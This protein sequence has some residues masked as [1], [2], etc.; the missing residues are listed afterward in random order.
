M[1]KR[2]LLIG[3]NFSPELTGIGKYSGEMMTWLAKRGYDCTVITG[4]PYYPYWKVQEPYFKN[5]FW[6]KTENQDFESGGHMKVYRCP[7]YVPAKPSGLKRI[8]LDFS[9]MVSAF[10][11]LFKL[12]FVKKYDYVLT[13]APSFQFGLLGTLYKK[14]R[15]GKLIY[16]IQDMQIEAARDLNM[17]NSPKVIDTL[18]RMENYI[19]QKAD[20]VSSISDEMVHRIE[21]KA[22]K[23]VYLFPNWAD[24]TKFYP[25]EDSSEL[26]RE[27]GFDPADKVILYSGAMGE[28]QGL[29]AILYAAKELQH[30]SQLKFV[31]C[32]S[33]PYK[34]TLQALADKLKIFNIVFLPLQP[35][36]KFNRFL[37]IADLHLII[38]KANASD[39]VMPSKL[40][41][42]LAVGGL[43]LITSNKESGL[44][45]MVSKHNLGILVEAENPVALYKGI[46]K[47]ISEDNTHKITN[48][49][50]YA[51]KYLSLDNVMTSFE[52]NVFAAEPKVERFVMRDYINVNPVHPVNNFN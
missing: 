10:L 23:P 47:A 52:E 19:F 9:F 45:K 41:T 39:L 1:K 2:V 49:R 44:H 29:E 48:A 46:L 3:Y 5:R 14:I 36:D 8:L 26:K 43:A 7:M 31:L 16:H 50:L 30:I 51:E 18:F 24:T 13:V 17:I 37:N 38:Q 28:K 11:I 35:I 33:G 6:Y 12:L 20:V 15:K 32:G 21:K 34:E 42:I 4:Y 40:T 27:F 22:N 25:I